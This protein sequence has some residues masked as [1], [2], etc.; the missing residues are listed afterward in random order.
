MN[1]HKWLPEPPVP[2]R[3]LD[4]LLCKRLGIPRKLVHPALRALKRAA[5]GNRVAG[6]E[7]PAPPPELSLGQDAGYRLFTATSL[8]GWQS[9]QDFACQRLREASAAASTAITGGNPRKQAFLRTLASGDELL[10]RADCLQLMLNESL[11]SAAVH[12]LGG[13]PQLAGA[14]LWWTPP[15]TGARRSQLWHLDDEDRH[16]VKVLINLTD[17]GPQQGPF[18]LIPAVDSAAIADSVA[19]NRLLGRLRRLGRLSDTDIGTEGSASAVPV[20]GP[21]G[22]GVLVDSS[23][24]LHHGSR[25]NQAD[26]LVL[27]FHYL[28]WDTPCSSTYRFARKGQLPD[29]ALTPLQRA[30][31]GLG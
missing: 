17:T 11:L 15:N 3:A 2:G 9:F 30:V 20:L 24:C 5:L 10:R 28:P 31:L 25:G 21:A 18:T 14:A 29:M 6:L 22:S 13:V 8:P 23:A 16:Q 27:M 19:E 26:R 4:K 7:T 12:Y 1:N